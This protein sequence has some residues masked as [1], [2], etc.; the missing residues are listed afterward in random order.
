MARQRVTTGKSIKDILSMSEDVLSGYSPSQQREIVSRLASAANKR[1]RNLEKN[2]AQTPA[3]LRIEESGGK[4]SVK[5]KTVDQVLNEFNRAKRFLQSQSS[6]V[7]GWKQQV[8][9]VKTAFEDVTISGK[10]EIKKGMSANAAIS[11]AFALYD[12]IAETNPELVSNK[13]R[14][15]IAGHIADVMYE[16]EDL[17]STLSQTLSWL[18]SEQETIREQYNRLQSEDVLG[19]RL[20][21]D[22]PKRFRRNRKSR[23]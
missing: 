18:E 9:Q 22:I 6:T 21:N 2:S 17:E 19:N 1:I 20:V 23:K 10:P 8:K 15:K 3:L 7:K 4:I 13:D 16:V 14:Y 12:V 11:Q 5:G